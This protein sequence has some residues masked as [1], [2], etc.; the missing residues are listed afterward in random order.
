[1]VPTVRF[2]PGHSKVVIAERKKR[3]QGIIQERGGTT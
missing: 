1:M 2:E 3:L